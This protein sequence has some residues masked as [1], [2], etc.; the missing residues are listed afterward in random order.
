MTKIIM[1]L[2]VLLL[3]TAC[4]GDCP[5]IDTQGYSDEIEYLQERIAALGDELAEM[6]GATDAMQKL[7]DSKV[8]I[9][10]SDS[11]SFSDDEL[12][13]SLLANKGLILTAV[14]GEGIS[15]SAEDITIGNGIVTVHVYIYVDRPYRN[16]RRPAEYFV[17]LR[18]H[19]LNEQLYWVVLPNISHE[20]T[21]R[22]PPQERMD[23]PSD[24]IFTVRFAWHYDDWVYP[25]R[26][27]YFYEEIGGRNWRG[28]AIYYLRQHTGIRAR[29]LWFEHA[30]SGDGQELRLV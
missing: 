8:E 18:Y 5:E 27:Y 13:R 17:Q 7:L 3:L 9:E 20:E 12:R 22:F 26:H 2:A 23:W 19:I 21:L 29:D 6:R 28:D 16:W 15:F 25:Y 30:A 1:I 4:G 24:S 14:G 11:H 10:T